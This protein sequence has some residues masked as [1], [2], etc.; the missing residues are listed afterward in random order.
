V[1]GHKGFRIKMQWI[2]LVSI[3]IVRV[4]VG[5]EGGREMN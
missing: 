2:Y 4:R 1:R 5:V 3:L